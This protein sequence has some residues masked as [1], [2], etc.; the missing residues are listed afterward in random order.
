MPAPFGDDVAFP[1]AY[2]QNVRCIT[3]QEWRRWPTHRATSRKVAGAI[4]SC[5]VFH[6]HNPFCRTVALGSTQPLTEMGTRNC[7]N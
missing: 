6:S 4:P 2:A 1:G 3:A 5:V 7:L